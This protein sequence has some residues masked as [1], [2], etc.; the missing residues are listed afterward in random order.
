MKHSYP[1]GCDVIDFKKFRFDRMHG[2][3]KTGF[4]KIFTLESVFRKAAFSGHR[5]HRIHEDGRP[6]CKKSRVFKRKRI[7]VNGSLIAYN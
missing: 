1:G 7:R 5:F 4:S 2:N 6:I 3:T